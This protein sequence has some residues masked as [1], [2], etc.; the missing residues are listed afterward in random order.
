MA[1]PDS[2]LRVESPLFPTILLFENRPFLFPGFPGGF[3]ERR[4]PGKNGKGSTRTLELEYLPFPC[5]SK[6]TLVREKAPVFRGALVGSCSRMIL[7][8]AW[9]KRKPTLF[10]RPF[11][12]V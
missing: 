1:P 4:T 10:G 5:F 7:T 9:N 2:T 12:E 11:N 6:I 3:P 8:P